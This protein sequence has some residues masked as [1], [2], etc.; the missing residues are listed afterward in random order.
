MKQNQK[1]VFKMKALKISN[2]VKKK[3]DRGKSKANWKVTEN[4][5][6]VQ[7]DNLLSEKWITGASFE[8]FNS[9]PSASPLLWF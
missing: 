5:V 1:Q 4:R 7:T 9:S 2:N 6:D 8:S 3:S